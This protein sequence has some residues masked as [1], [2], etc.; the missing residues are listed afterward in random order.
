MGGNGG[1][2]IFP[3]PPAPPVSLPLSTAVSR[4]AENLAQFLRAGTRSREVWVLVGC[5]G[6]VIFLCIIYLCFIILWNLS[7]PVFIATG[8]GP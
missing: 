6:L 8:L 7:D 5:L 2:T 4:S 1:H 3:P